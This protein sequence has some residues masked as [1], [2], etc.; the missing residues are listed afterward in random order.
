VVF[1]RIPE[2][3]IIKKKTLIAISVINEYRERT[4]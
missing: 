1:F 2:D 4:S 3:A